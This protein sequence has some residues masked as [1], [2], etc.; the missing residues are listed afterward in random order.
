MCELHSQS[1]VT[2]QRNNIVAASDILILLLLSNVKIYFNKKFFLISFNFT[3]FSIIYLTNTRFHKIH[4]NR[5]VF[6]EKPI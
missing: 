6:A 3:F 4:E 2:E 5:F 1:I